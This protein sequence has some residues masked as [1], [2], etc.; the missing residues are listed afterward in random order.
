MTLF[1][2]LSHPSFAFIWTGQTVS[3]LGDSLYRIALSWWVL[4]KTGSAAIMGSVLIFSFTPMLIFSLIGGVAVDRFPRLKVMV[5]S[6]VLRGLA[7]LGVAALAFAGRLEIWHVFAAS[8]LFGLVDAF[9]Q[10]AYVAVLPEIAPRE[11]LPSANS[12]TNLSSQ[13]ANIAGPA[14]GAALVGLGGTPTAF[15]LD[16]LSFFISAAC[17]LPLLKLPLPVRAGMQGLNLGQEL[18]VGVR[19]VLASPWLWVT[20]A[21]AA[22][23]NVTISGPMSV[24]LP[25]L[26]SDNL[27]RDVG[28]LGLIYSVS[29]I[30]SVLGAVWLGRSTRLRRRGALAYGAW[31]V[32]GLMVM[33]FGLP[34]PVE[35][36]LLA[37]L[38]NGAALSTFGLVWTNTLQ[39]MV[40]GDLLGRVASIDNLGSFVLLPV[41]YGVAGLLTDKVGAPLVFAVGGV[42]TALLAVLGLLHPAIRKLD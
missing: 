11:L 13:F 16:G 6:D 24:S 31:V 1:K 25:F 34:V 28:T 18:K 21:I 7:V 42:A 38:V 37:S 2:S 35:V 41:G 4:E 5:A 30:G 22:L 32:T 15:A 36:I 20:I 19:A 12:L 9:F 3:R 10:P 39:E 40:P 27:H 23:S 26:V 8:V 29:S 14:L 17:L 33:V